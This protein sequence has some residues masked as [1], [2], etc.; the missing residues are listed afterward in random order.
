MRAAGSTSRW[1]AC[2]LAAACWLACFACD[3]P[4]PALTGRL[5]APVDLEVFKGCP[6]HLPECAEEE[7]HFLLAVVS[8]QSD[9]VRIFDA[10]KR[11]FFSSVNPFFPLSVP[12]GRYPSCAGM[13][14]TGEFL[15]VA[16]G[17][18]GDLSLVDLD[19]LVEVD[20]DRDTTTCA[21][22]LHPDN[23]RCRAGVSRAPLSFDDES[24][25]APESIAVPRG[26]EGGEEP[27]WSRDKM[28]PVWV[29]L[30]LSG[31]LARLEFTYPL[32]EGI[33]Q[34]LDLAEIVDVGGVPSGLAITHDGA[35]LVM[36]DEAS[37]SIAVLDTLSLSLDRV[38]AGGPTRR[39]FLTPDEQ[40]VYAVRLDSPEIRLVDLQSR[41]PVPTGYEALPDTARN[42][43]EDGSS[44]ML[45]GIPRSITFVEGHSLSVLDEGSESIDYTTE[46]LPEEEREGVDQEVIRLFAYVSD[47]DGNVYLLDAVNHRTVDSQPFYGP[48]LGEIG[49]VQRGEVIQPEELASCI[50]AESCP[51][52]QIEDFDRVYDGVDE[53]DPIYHGVWLYPGYTRSESWII[54]WEGV[55]PGTD[56]SSSGRFDGWTLEDERYGLDY[57]AAGVQAGDYLQV[58]SPPAGVGEVPDPACV[59]DGKEDAQTYFRVESVDEKSLRLVEVSGVDPGRCWPEAIRYQ[60]RVRESWM[61][62]GTESGVMGDR[63]EMGVRYDN[64]MIALT[65][66][67]PTSLDE[68]EDPIRVPRDAAF[69][70]NADSGFVHARFAPSIRAGVAGELVS[71]DIDGEEDDEGRLADDSVFLLFESSNAL[72]EFFPGSFESTNYLLYQ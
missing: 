43:D 5:Y 28:L 13:D 30:S 72:M 12:V 54:T 23:E 10:E 35:T 50:G 19:R 65:I 26:V 33:P 11:A 34:R 57:G 71:I 22:S 37:D 49:Y 61:V 24:V 45:P 64:G 2:M 17:L 47:M 42:P 60:V 40:I 52:P 20:C 16:N 27:S 46:L 9:D 66:L 48:A 70:F 67:A 56:Q 39:V 58:L 25:L 1:Q 29:S 6:Q 53:L 62:V 32:G 3:E 4:K 14:P 51:Y 38:D 59:A 55:L 8:S 21:S 36:A 31:Q 63:I 18:S 69:G 44:L 41:A 7:K 68:N 15:F